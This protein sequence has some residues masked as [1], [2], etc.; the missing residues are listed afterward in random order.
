MSLTSPAGPINPDEAPNYE[1]I[2]KQFAVK[3]EPW[4]M[5]FKSDGW[6]C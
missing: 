2:E 5:R 1:E 6:R 4:C 3:G